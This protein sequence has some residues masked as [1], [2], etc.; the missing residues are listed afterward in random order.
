MVNILLDRFQTSVSIAEQLQS[1]STRELFANRQKGSWIAEKEVAVKSRFGNALVPTITPEKRLSNSSPSRTDLLIIVAAHEKEL[2][3][4]RDPESAG[5]Q[6]A[7]ETVNA[8]IVKYRPDVV[9]WVISELDQFNNLPQFAGLTVAQIKEGLVDGTLALPDNYLKVTDAVMDLDA[10]EGAGDPNEADYRQTVLVPI[11]EKVVQAVAQAAQETKS[12]TITS[13]PSPPSKLDAHFAKEADKRDQINL[14][15]ARKLL[16]M[17]VRLIDAPRNIDSVHN[18]RIATEEELDAKAEQ[19]IESRQL[20]LRQY[21]YLQELHTEN[22]DINMKL[23]EMGLA[24]ADSQPD[25]LKEDLD[26]LTAK[27]HDMYDIDAKKPLQDVSSLYYL[28]IDEQN[29]SHKQQ[30][31]IRSLVKEITLE[32]LS[33]KDANFALANAVLRYG[34]PEQKEAILKTLSATLGVEYKKPD[35]PKPAENQV[36][37]EH[38]STAEWQAVYPYLQEINPRNEDMALNPRLLHHFFDNFQGLGSTV[39]GLIGNPGAKSDLD[40]RISH[41]QFFKKQ[42]ERFEQLAEKIDASIVREICQQ[43]INAP[44]NM[45]DG[46]IEEFIARLKDAHNGSSTDNVVE[47]IDSWNNVSS[48][49]TLLEGKEITDRR[50]KKLFERLSSHPLITH[51][52]KEPDREPFAEN[53]ASSEYAYLQEKKWIDVLRMMDYMDGVAQ[54]HSYP[55]LA[56]VVKH[57]KDVEWLDYPTP[58]PDGSPSSFM[59]QTYQS[60]QWVKRLAKEIDPAV[61]TAFPQGEANINETNYQEALVKIDPTWDNTVKVVH[62]L[63]EK[64]NRL[65]LDFRLTEDT[66]RQLDTPEKKMAAFLLLRYRISHLVKSVAGELFESGQVEIADLKNLYERNPAKVAG[67][68]VETFLKSTMP[69]IQSGLDWINELYQNPLFTNRTPS[70]STTQL[71]ELKEYVVRADNANRDSDNVSLADSEFRKKLQRALITST[72]LA[73]PVDAVTAAANSLATTP[74]DQV[75]NLNPKDFSLDVLK[76]A[77]QIMEFRHPRLNSP[78]FLIAETKIPPEEIERYRLITQLIKQNTQPAQSK[79]LEQTMGWTKNSTTGVGIR[80]ADGVITANGYLADDPNSPNIT[81]SD[82]IRLIDNTSGP[83]LVSSGGFV[84]INN[85]GHPVHFSGN[86]TGLIESSTGLPELTLSDASSAQTGRGITSVNMRGSSTLYLEDQSD[87]AAIFTTLDDRQNS[88]PD[89]M[90]FST[91]S[92]NIIVSA[93]VSDSAT[94]ET[95]LSKQIN[96]KLYSLPSASD[97]SQ[98]DAE[99]KGYTL[100]K[101]DGRTFVFIRAKNKSKP[102]DE[103]LTVWEKITFKIAGRE[104]TKLVFVDGRK[105]DKDGLADLKKRVAKKSGIAD[106]ELQIPEPGPNIRPI[107]RRLAQKLSLTPAQEDQLISSLKKDYFANP[108]YQ[109]NDYSMTEEQL[110]QNLSRIEDDW[111]KIQT[112]VKLGKKFISRAKSRIE[113]SERFKDLV[114]TMTYALMSGDDFKVDKKIIRNI[115]WKMYGALPSDKVIINRDRQNEVVVG[116][117]E[118]L[119][120]F[121]CL[122]IIANL[123]PNSGDNLLHNIQP[124]FVGART[125]S[126]SIQK[127]SRRDAV[128]LLGTVFGG[129]AIG[130]ATHT[131]GWDTQIA[132]AAGLPTQPNYP[133]NQ[134]VARPASPA[135]TTNSPSQAIAAQPTNTSTAEA[136][137]AAQPTN[138]PANTKEVI[139]AKED[140]LKKAQLIQQETRFNTV[141]IS[142]LLN[143][144]PETIKPEEIPDPPD[145]GTAYLLALKGHTKWQKVFF[146][147]Y[148]HD[149]V[150][151]SVAYNTLYSWI[152][153]NR[154]DRTWEPGKQN[155]ININPDDGSFAQVEGVKFEDDITLPNG[156]VISGVKLYDQRLD[157]KNVGILERFWF[158]VFPEGP[159]ADS[160]E[161]RLGLTKARLDPEVLEKVIGKIY[162]VADGKVEVYNPKDLFSGKNKS[163]FAKAENGGFTFHLCTAYKKEAQIYVTPNPNR[164]TNRGS[165]FFYKIVAQTFKSSIADKFPVTNADVHS[166]S[167]F[168]EQFKQK[169]KMVIKDAFPISERV[170]VKDSWVKNIDQEGLGRI[171]LRIPDL[172][173]LSRV[174][175]VIT[176]PDQNIPP[177]D[178]SLQELIGIPRK[179][180]AYSNRFVTVAAGQNGGITISINSDIPLPKNSRIQIMTLD[181]AVAE[182]YW[183]HKPSDIGNLRLGIVNQT[184]ERD[185]SSDGTQ[186]FDPLKKDFIVNQIMTFVDDPKVDIHDLNAQMKE[187]GLK[188]NQ[189]QFIQGYIEGGVLVINPE[190]KIR[191]LTSGGEDLG[192]AGFYTWIVPSETPA[193]NLDGMFFFGKGQYRYTYDADGFATKI[194]Y[195]DKDRMFY[196]A[197]DNSLIKLKKGDRLL[198]RPGFGSF[199]TARVQA[200]LFGYYLV[201]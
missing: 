87:Y 128:K 192:G 16:E 22:M 23:V 66:Y 88:K 11:V 182:C 84:R 123:I 102:P 51:A 101:R 174:K 150:Q 64:H 94:S 15:N 129:V 165:E 146:P 124:D 10:Y 151:T 158:S 21:F 57:V 156:E 163:V 116:L 85:I 31:S 28:L 53:H 46:D 30:K 194:D 114:E 138:A 95:D 4:I 45:A 76:K 70:A 119:S 159:I 198:M 137:A 96:Y 176:Y 49:Q 92:K 155:I 172:N 142:N 62:A 183:Q 178:I 109:G 93:D 164:A 181:N 56:S 144:P 2:E 32:Q 152:D 179:D 14:E 97:I 104:E 43:Y 47:F 26:I 131:L 121:Q 6:L 75:Q 27:K 169:D 111:D 118:L 166:R 48:L 81:I 161:A 171:S 83:I 168:F 17:K 40:P 187:I 71:T 29:I 149:N 86:G 12:P 200:T 130:L 59:L 186:T 79:T 82:Q 69:N 37:P 13:P 100:S 80:D 185:K 34:S 24:M 20:T 5:F 18:S 133:S 147:N 55:H 113:E 38:F 60:V 136:A 132:A 120:T 99:N 9:A 58:N 125:N 134:P 98:A 110:I 112:H 65:S 106:F 107:V 148:R 33:D 41:L 105:A 7:R 162:V 25:L 8:L 127:V 44:Q 184:L 52:N 42:I 153:F 78:P 175:L 108:Q 170:L 35:T 145:L 141:K 73:F 72:P 89:I 160:I 196:F 180:I 54:P 177:I 74:V 3:N 68:A 117:A 50:V 103:A 36:D 1:D 39:E 191:A 115:V 67:S 195:S 91:G 63:L 19:A 77:R 143:N 154:L 189:V 157:G 139:S 61:I 173:S 197:F 190:G 167:V 122:N 140:A 126:E 201:D 90:V 193:G 199:E 135:P 188:P